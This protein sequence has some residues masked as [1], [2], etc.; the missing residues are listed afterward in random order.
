MFPAATNFPQR[1]QKYYPMVHLIGG[2]PE[3]ERPHPC[4]TPVALATSNFEAVL[5]LLEQHGVT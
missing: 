5:T 2:D 1:R 3:E 4:S